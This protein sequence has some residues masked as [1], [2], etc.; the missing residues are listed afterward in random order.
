MS[1]H[2]VSSSCGHPLVHAQIELTKRDVGII[3]DPAVSFPFCTPR[4]SWIL[5]LRHNT[6]A[7]ELTE[8]RFGTLTRTPRHEVFQTA[9]SVTL[10]IDLPGCKKQD[11]DAQISE[12]D[13]AKTL[14]ITAVRRR[15]HNKETVGVDGSDGGSRNEGSGYA[16]AEPFE[17]ERSPSVSVPSA[18][19]KFELSFLLGEGIDV[20]RVRGNMED[21]VLTLVLP[22][23]PRELPAQPIDIPIDCPE[24]GDRRVSPE[25]AE[26]PDGGDGGDKGRAANTHVSLS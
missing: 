2:H 13:G 23:V 14:R 22:R 26:G 8:S 20:S 3:F 1:D 21:G 9:E 25:D 5:I 17:R 10:N 16:G 18:E 12:D 11:V 15:P 19:E 4:H 6:V 7:R 24:E